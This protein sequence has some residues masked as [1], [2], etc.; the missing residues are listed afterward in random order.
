MLCTD[1][2]CL[3]DPGKG[4]LGVVV[5]DTEGHV[6]DRRSGPARRTTNNQMELV[7]IGRRPGA[8]CRPVRQNS[9]LFRQPVRVQSIQR[10]LA[11]KLASQRLA[12]SQP[13]AGQKSGPVGPHGRTGRI[14]ILPTLGLPL[15]ISRS[16][17]RRLPQYYDGLQY[18]QWP[19]WQAYMLEVIA[20]AARETNY[21]LRRHSPA[22]PEAERITDMAE[23]WEAP[24]RG[25]RPISAQEGQLLQLMEQIR[26]INSEPPC[27]PTRP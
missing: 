11:Q 2:S 1:G 3:G 4:S 7:A 13:A 24:R 6:L 10:R 12:H 25:R 27:E 17:Y 8:H 18:A 26:R 9:G 16:I 15:T 23:R 19:Q 5:T 20:E 21:D 14:W 22:L